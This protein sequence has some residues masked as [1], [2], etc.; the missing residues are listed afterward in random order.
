MKY[1]LKIIILFFLILE[2]PAK[3][4]CFDKIPKVYI[5]IRNDY[6]IEIDS[7]RI[8]DTIEPNLNTYKI[9]S[10]QQKIKAYFLHDSISVIVLLQNGKV[11]RSNK[12]KVQTYDDYFDLIINNDKINLIRTGDLTLKRNLTLII[13]LILFPFGLK[14]LPS[15]IYIKPSKKIRYLILSSLLNIG[16]IV[17]IFCSVNIIHKF[18]VIDEFNTGLVLIVI[19]VI[20]DSIIYFY[21]YTRKVKPIHLISCIFFTN[22]LFY[23]VGGFFICFTLL[24]F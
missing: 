21:I 3:V 11:M 9:T 16:Y 20:I 18:K 7:I 14:S 12:S 5:S 8:V 23:F 13:M 15:L 2:L 6:K 10:Y 24:L 22:L 1:L 4:L 19:S 17:F